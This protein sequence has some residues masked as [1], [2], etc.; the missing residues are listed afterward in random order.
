MKTKAIFVLMAVLFSLTVPVLSV[1]AESGDSNNVPQE[2]SYA[3]TITYTAGSGASK[4]THKKNYTVTAYSSS[5]AESK[6]TRMWESENSSYIKSGY[7]VF[8]HA[9]AS[10]R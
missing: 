2:Y 8:L 5:E 3:V 7:I 4:V 10:R 9:S 1:F 6:A